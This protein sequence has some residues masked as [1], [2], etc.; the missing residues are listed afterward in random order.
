ME[1]SKIENISKYLSKHILTPVI[2]MSEK[3]TEI[4]FICFCD[5]NV[6]TSEVF[7]VEQTLSN[8]LQKRVVIA[9]IREFSEIDRL[10]IIKESTLIYCEDPLLQQVFEMSMV[11]DFRIAFAKKQ[12]VIERS[13]SCNSVYI[14]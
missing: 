7:E 9:D 1:I 10:D 2:Y 12:E 8:M 11:E 5:N 4:S 3:D 6:T 13:K 14:S